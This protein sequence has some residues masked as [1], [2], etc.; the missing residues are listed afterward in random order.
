MRRARPAAARSR[1]QGPPLPLSLSRARRQQTTWTPRARFGLRVLRVESIWGHGVC[2]ECGRWRA[3]RARGPPHSPHAR[4]YALT[5]VCAPALEGVLARCDARPHFERTS[6][7]LDAISMQGDAAQVAAQR[8]QPALARLHGACRA[9]DSSASRR[10]PPRAPPWP[11]TGRLALF[12]GGYS[13][14]TRR[15]DLLFPLR[16]MARGPLLKQPPWV[17]WPSRASDRSL[18]AR[19]Q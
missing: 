5:R 7:D 4:F 19:Q 6:R 15:A 1:S 18:R 12:R 3:C 14:L 16:S 10:R 11:P 8:V 2:W 9:A 17:H 13:V